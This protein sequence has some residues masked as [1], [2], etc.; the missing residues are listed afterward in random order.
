MTFGAD[1]RVDTSKSKRM[2]IITG[3]KTI[4]AITTGH[5]LLDKKRN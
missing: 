1:T 2:P 4:R 3:M 5:T